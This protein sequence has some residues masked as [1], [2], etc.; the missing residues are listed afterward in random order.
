MIKIAGFELALFQ[1]AAT[2][3]GAG[4]IVFV[5]ELGHFI[6][7]KTYKLRVEKFAFGFGPEIF[8]FTKGETRYS[9]CAIPLG[10]M[11]KMP[12]EDP[13]S[14]TG[15]P[16]EFYSQKWYKRLVIAFF[17]PFMNYVLAALIFAFVIY[18]WGLARPSDQPVIGD[19]VEGYPA[20]K[21]GVL[22]GDRILSIN[23]FEIKD[24]MQ[25]AGYIHS[26]SD[27]MLDMKVLR[28]GKELDINVQPKFDKAAGTGLIGIAPD[29]VTEKEG[30]LYSC[31]LGGKMTVVQSVLT[32]QYLGQK[33]VHLE[34]PDL[35]G[36]IGVVQFIAKAA[37]SGMR[38]LLG[39]LAVISTALGL[40][41]LLPIPILD[42]GHIFI[43][44]IEGAIRRPLGKKAIMT[45]NM[46]GL[47]II[48]CIFIFATY[49]D[50]ARLVN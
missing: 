29:A 46:V 25:L 21:A 7:A 32:L 39:F 45:A 9:I 6:M 20:M 22:A 34:K 35:A 50:I 48:V 36:P 33:I 11:V 2:V 40:F 1:I 12:G 43:A 13:D 26:H 30:L 14:S 5:H 18:F 41:N 19:V 8:G 27:K 23:G 10:G 4:F 49:N 44:L 38:D 3:I 42:G 31:Y 37:R 17:G 28:K 15:S 16:D 47:S 24:W